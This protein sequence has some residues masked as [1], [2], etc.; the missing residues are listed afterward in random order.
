MAL[1]S[2]GQISLQDIQDEFG[3]SHP[4]SLSEYYGVD[5]VPASGE[6]SCNDFYGTSTQFILQL[7]VVQL[8]QMVIT[9]YINS[10]VMV[11]SLS[12]Q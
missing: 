10:Q 12:H 2:S 5:T 9:K 4:I 8:L 1:Q 6:I 7:R 3:G 11:L